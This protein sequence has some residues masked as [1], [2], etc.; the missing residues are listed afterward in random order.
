MT[1]STFDAMPLDDLWDLHKRVL[2]I[3]EERLNH[4]RQKVEQQLKQL[5]RKFGG[6][7]FDT[8]ERRPHPKVPQKYCNPEFPS[9]TWSGRGKQPRWVKTLMASGASLEDVRIDTAKSIQDWLE[10]AGR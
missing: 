8:G 4:E 7:R 10:R 3:L 2:S 9:Q 1:H 5:S 6:P